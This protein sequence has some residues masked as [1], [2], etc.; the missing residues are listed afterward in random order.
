MV[1]STITDILT[2]VARTMKQATTG[3]AAILAVLRQ[4]GP[5]KMT[6][7]AA[8][9]GVTCPALTGLADSMSAKGWVVRLVDVNDRRAVLL[10]I[11]PAGLELVRGW[12]EAAMES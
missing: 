2:V 9:V 7:C 8:H 12:E 6:A 10:G 5:M 3:Q 1:M 4:H 11:A